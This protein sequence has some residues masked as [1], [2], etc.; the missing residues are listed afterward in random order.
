M[1]PPGSKRDNMKDEVLAT[2]RPMTVGE[3]IAFE[4]SAEV[5]HEFINRR[6]AH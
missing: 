6:S 4:E 3:Y 1:L 5:R 2:S